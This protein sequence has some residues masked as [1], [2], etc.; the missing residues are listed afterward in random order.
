MYFLYAKMHFFPEKGTPHS[1]Q[2]HPSIE[3][4]TFKEDFANP[5]EPQYTIQL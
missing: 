3:R 2:N 5:H 1:P 4:L